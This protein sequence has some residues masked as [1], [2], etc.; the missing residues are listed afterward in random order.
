[1]GNGAYAQIGQRVKAYRNEKGFS[2]EELADGIR[3]SST[4]SLL[5]NG[6]HIPSAEMMHK[7]A[8]RLSIPLQEILVDQE[9]ELE[10]KLQ[11]D[12]VKVFVESR[13]F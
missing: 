11:V 13:R 6:Q 4:I 2:Q 9:H 7:I 3:S 1:M 10:T 8:E 12:F 5:E